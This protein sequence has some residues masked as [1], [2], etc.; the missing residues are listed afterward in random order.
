MLVIPAI[1]LKDGQCVR[2]KQGKFSDKIIYSNEP[3]KMAHHFCDKGAQRLH[4][5]DLDGAESGQSKNRE[6]LLALARE[7]D[8][9]IQ[10]GGGI[11]THQDIEFWLTQGIATVIIGTLATRDPEI[12]RGAIQEFGPERITLS[13]D[14]KEGRVMTHGWQTESN[15]TALDLATK[16]KPH[17]LQ[18]IL[19]TDIARDGMFTGPNIS[20]TKELAQQSG[21]KV[22][23]SGGV[24][25]AKDL[26]R[27]AEL[28]IFGVDSVVV[29]KAFYEN[30]IKP[31][32][33]F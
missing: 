8:V 21:L 25:S 28:E 33:V 2:L 26:Q 30:K 19:Y 3:L 31:E 27:L 5:V 16:F 13:V 18:R 11:R 14:A 9:P 10:L 12:V 20:A 1:D 6:V 17:G 29:G 22:T 4:V 7:V 23:A 32:E 24:S 15:Y